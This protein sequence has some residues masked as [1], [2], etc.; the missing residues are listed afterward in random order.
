MVAWAGF[1]GAPAA[2]G[3]E[4]SNLREVGRVSRRDPPVVVQIAALRQAKDEANPVSLHLSPRGDDANPGTQKRPRRSLQQIDA[5]LQ[6]TPDFTAVVLHAGIY[7]GAA[8]INPLKDVPEAAVPLLLIRA[9]EGEEVILDGS[10]VSLSDATPVPG[11]PGVFSQTLAGDLPRAPALWESDTRTRYI[12]AADLTAV[13]HYPA[14]YSYGAGRLYFHTSDGKPPKAHAL[15]ISSAED[16]GLLIY[17]PNTTVR[18]IWFRNNV[19]SPKASAG[20]SVRAR[21]CLVED[22]RASNCP[23]GFHLGG[24]DNRLLSCR[25][26]DVSQGA[27]A[28]G[29]NITVQGCRF[30]KKRDAFTPGGS[31]QDDT[32]IQFYYP[33]KGGVARGNLCVGFANGVFIKTW[34]AAYLVEHNTLISPAEDL[35]SNIG[36]NFGMGPTGWTESHICRY[37]IV[38]GYHAPLVNLTLPKPRT[39]QH[40]CFWTSARPGRIADGPRFEPPDTTNVFADPR[41]ADTETGDYRLLKDSPCLKKHGGA[42]GPCGALPAVGDDFR[43]TAPPHVVISAKPPVIT[44][45]DN[46]RAFPLLVSRTPEFPLEVWAHDAV[47]RP[48]QMRVRIGEAPWGE[49][50]PLKAPLRVEFPP[51][52]TRMAVSVRVADEA[53]NWS[54]PQSVQ[55][56]LEQEPPRPRLVGAVEVRSNTHGVAIAFRTSEATRAVLEYGPTAS[57]GRQAKSLR[58]LSTQHAIVP[59]Y[60]SLIGAGAIHYRLRLASELGVEM[61]TAA[62]LVA[63]EGGPRTLVVAPADG[64]DDADGS[65]ARPWKTLRHALDRALPGDTVLLK[66]GLYR[67]G[68]TLTHG[69]LPG[70]PIRILSER[71]WGAVLDGARV[72]DAPLALRS[73]RHVEVEGLESRWFHGIGIS[74]EDSPDVRVSGCKVWNDFFNSGLW[75]EGYGICAK[76]SPGFIADHNLTYSTEWGL[77]VWDSPNSK[78]LSNTSTCHTYACA[79]FIGTGLRGTVCRNNDFAFGGNDVLVYDVQ[80]GQREWIKELDSDYNNLGAHLRSSEGQMVQDDNPNGLKVDSVTPPDAFLQGGKAIVAFL[81]GGWKPGCR[82]LSMDD[83]RAVSGQEKHSIFADPRHVSYPRYRFELQ[84]DSP[85]L[86]AGEKGATIGAFGPAH[87]AAAPPGP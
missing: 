16:Y 78:L 5:W 40:N 18:G 43:D 54:K 2:S 58:V 3:A 24:E 68:A 7:Y 8:T 87:G 13:A 48:T 19:T 11:A 74:V 31:G 29:T 56:R 23:I 76:D 81:V 61:V 85:N 20:V 83:W 55:C 84:P 32:G 36:M 59:P 63:L 44:R 73:V 15:G 71:R 46:E 6:A 60:D 62:S 86:G 75:A 34:P 39:V 49:A 37:N 64:R 67:G 79:T 30:V 26:E 14:S 1:I 69:G 50:V 27:Y 47:S 25:A 42:T 10:G 65:A 41:F 21:N 9:A 28:D 17:R 53:G 12:L 82:H 22:C 72:A 45:Q 38:V 35:S 80:E 4:Q 57:C 51:G 70:S 77:V 66:P 33:S 52:T